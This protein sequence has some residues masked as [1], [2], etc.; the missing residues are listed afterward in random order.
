MELTGTQ[1]EGDL[2]VCIPLVIYRHDT[3][4]P[5]SL[6]YAGKQ[7]VTFT[8]KADSLEKVKEVQVGQGNWKS[9]DFD[10]GTV[11]VREFSI[12]PSTL[13]IKFK[14]TLDSP[15]AEEQMNQIFK[16]QVEDANGNT[17]EIMTSSIGDMYTTKDGKANM[18]VEMKIMGIY[19]DTESLTVYMLTSDW[20][21]DG[22]H[23]PGKEKEVNSFM[24]PVKE[25]LEE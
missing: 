10:G 20:D 4:N 21:S 22:K 3:A 12:A 13:K 25:I 16:F 2:E 17:G 5:Q 6:S 7:E 9:Y 24:L 23:I 14:Y 1:V 11:E 19:P 8:V 15:D 18:I